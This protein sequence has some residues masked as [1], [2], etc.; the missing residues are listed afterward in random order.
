MAAGVMTVSGSGLARE[1]F[2]R[3]TLIGR[4]Y[5]NVAIATVLAALHAIPGTGWAAGTVGALG[6]VTARFDGVPVMAALAK[7]AEVEDAHI[8]FSPTTRSY[9]FDVF[10]AAS[11][12]ALINAADIGPGASLNPNIGFIK[13]LVILDESAASVNRI[14]PYGA[15]EGNNAWTMQY[16]TR[17][18][19][20]GDPYNIN[21][22]A[23]P[24]GE[25][26]YYLEDAAAITALGGSPRGI[27]EKVVLFKDVAPIANSVLA[28]ELASNAL[29]DLAA[30][31]LARGGPQVTYAVEATKLEGAAFKIGDTIRLLFNGVV[32]E[33]TG[34]R[35]WKSVDANVIVL[36]KKRTFSPGSEPRWDLVVSTL[37]KWRETEMTQIIGAIETLQ[38]FKTAIKPYTATAMAGPARES[39]EF[40]TTKWFALKITYRAN[41][42]GI[43]QAYLNA[44]IKPLKSN[45]TAASSGGGSTS[46]APS[47]TKSVAIASHSHDHAHHHT[48]GATGAPSGTTGTPNIPDTNH[49][50]TEVGAPGPTGGP[51]AHMTFNYPSTAHTHTVP[52]SSALIT[53]GGGIGN[54]TGALEGIGGGGVDNVADDLHTHNVSAHVHGLTYGIFESTLP[55]A[56]AVQVWI[57]GTNRT[58]AL[59]GPWNAD[60]SVDI[61]SYLTDAGGRPLW[62]TNTVEFRKPTT[63]PDAIDIIADVQSLAITTGLLPA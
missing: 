42:Q 40:S 1:F 25:Q 45:A 51:S 49:T 14:I 33:D 47:G 5:S 26:Y 34:R 35:S 57:N 63:S 44:Q 41:I 38:A 56:P 29:Y 3:N 36:E 12:V 4:Q 60:F 39:I 59:G 19:G 43:L 2:Y 21:T 23:G 10:G 62:G 54:K 8:R 11:G 15:G 6:N 53:D 27:R 61:T 46:T 58:I 52:N 30:T 50:H 22:A 37:G 17:S 31:A 32:V 13:K 16:S 55:A 20:A 18:V 48:T 24:D 28:F 7:L 9:D